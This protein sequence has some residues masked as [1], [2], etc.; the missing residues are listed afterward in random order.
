MFGARSFGGMNLI[1]NNTYKI[2]QNATGSVPQAGIA[3]MDQNALSKFNTG[4]LYNVS[5][6]IGSITEGFSGSA[7]PKDLEYL[8]QS[9][10]AYFTDLN[11]DEKSI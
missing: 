11:Y 7:T 9:V 2:V 4:K 8:F 6:Y 3:G 5:P 1:D 10:Y